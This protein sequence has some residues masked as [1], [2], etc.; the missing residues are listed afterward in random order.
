MATTAN[1]HPFLF[2]LAVGALFI[3]AVPL[4]LAQS[5]GPIEAM[6]VG[7][8]HYEAGQYAQAAEVYESIL[9]AG[10]AGSALYYNL[11]NA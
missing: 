4:A 10:V 11:V 7:N 2:W 8:Q 5:V 3:C 6:Q 9:A 1:R